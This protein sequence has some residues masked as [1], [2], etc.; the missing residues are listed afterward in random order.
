MKLISDAWLWGWVWVAECFFWYRPT[1]VVP[2]YWWLLNSCLRVL[3][4]VKSEAGAIA[5]TECIQLLSALYNTHIGF[6]P[7]A[8]CMFASNA[9]FKS[10]VY[11]QC[12]LLCCF[13]LCFYFCSHCIQAS[14]SN[15]DDC[16]VCAHNNRVVICHFQYQFSWLTR[17]SLL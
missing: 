9:M 4:T 15:L 1:R 11:W 13:V 17:C 7:R 2:D 6:S 10:P 16:N 14:S 12:S 8:S 3:W 5:E